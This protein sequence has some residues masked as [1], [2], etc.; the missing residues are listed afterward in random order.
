MLRT[1]IIISVNGANFP[2]PSS[3]TIGQAESRI[4]SRF[5]LQFGSLEDQNGALMDEN[6]SIETAIGTISFVGGQPLQLVGHYN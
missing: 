3:A 6:A 4:R 5:G 1:P 2:C